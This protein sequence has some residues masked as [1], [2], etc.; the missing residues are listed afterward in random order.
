M[1]G[2]AAM[3]AARLSLYPHYSWLAYWLV[4][5]PPRVFELSEGRH[6]SHQLL[7]TTA[8]EAHLAWTSAGHE[9]LF[10]ST[11]GDLG[12]YPCDHAKYQLAITATEGYRAYAILLPD[13]HLQDMQRSE[14]LRPEADLHAMPV[15]RDA[16]IRASLLRLADG[17]GCRQV[18]ESVGDEIAARQI[19][20]RLCALA[21]GGIPDWT[22]DTSVF[23][24]CVMR[25]IV[26]R[27]DAHLAGH[28]SLEYMSQGFGLSPS[29]FARKF[30]QSTGLSLNR[31]MNR[32]RISLALALLRSD[33]TPLAQLSL[34]L[35]FCSQSHFTRLFR[36]LTGLTPLQFSRAR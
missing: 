16:L 32:R 21:G 31:F 35:G 28:P 29:H 1:G 3:D 8:G 20:M 24:P 10:Q 27:V 2:T 6:V 36:G 4:V 25:R 19:V 26:E 15:F 9:V 33:N 7:L 17:G 22:K 18:S 14:D 13:K 23:Q 12:F 5:E 34:D 30:Q 11:A